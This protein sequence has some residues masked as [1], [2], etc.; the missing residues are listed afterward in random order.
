MTTN[1]QMQ[2]RFHKMP[3]ETESH[4]LMT[5]QVNNLAEAVE[6]E[7]PDGTM[8]YGVVTSEWTEIRSQ[9][10]MTTTKTVR[11][12]SIEKGDTE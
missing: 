12:H 8:L 2:I 6:V 9:S 4:G 10:Q 1:D 11:V 5:M 3:L 7:L